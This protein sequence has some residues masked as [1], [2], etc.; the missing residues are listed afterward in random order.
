[1]KKPGWLVLRHILDQTGLLSA[2][3]WA[4]FSRK[5]S[6]WFYSRYGEQF[7]HKICKMLKFRIVGLV[8]QS[9]FLTSPLTVVA[10]AL[11][12][13]SGCLLAWFTR[14]RLVVYVIF[15]CRW[16]GPVI[17]YSWQL[18]NNILSITHI[19][20]IL[21]AEELWNICLSSC[22][23]SGVAGCGWPDRVVR[24]GIFLY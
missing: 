7:L 15:C 1:M 16:G 18:R 21:I 20:I 6:R 14:F 4:G 17:N 22:S 13:Q 11:H 23:G 12:N 2:V 5:M 10:L 24:T 8:C 9:I 19:D 3:R